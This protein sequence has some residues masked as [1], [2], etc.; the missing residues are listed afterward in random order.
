MMSQRVCSALLLEVPAVTRPRVHGHHQ[1]C[2]L[3]GRYFMCRSA[4]PPPTRRATPRARPVTTN[5]HPR[6]NKRFLTTSKVRSRWTARTTMHHRRPFRQYLRSSQA[7]H[8]GKL[9]S[10]Q[11]LPAPLLGDTRTSHPSTP[12]IPSLS[13]SLSHALFFAS[14]RHP[15]LCSL[16]FYRFIPLPRHH[17]HRCRRRPLSELPHYNYP[18]ATSNQTLPVRCGWPHDLCSH[19]R[20]CRAPTEAVTTQNTSTS[21]LSANNIIGDTNINVDSALSLSLSLRRYLFAA[22]PLSRL[23][24]A[25]RCSAVRKSCCMR[26]CLPPLMVTG[27]TC[28]LCCPSFAFAHGH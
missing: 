1:A 9:T 25:S 26:G 7:K 18:R 24:L 2:R 4:R 22:I 12:M 19:Y 23:P 20:S 16:A 15:T 8:H 3:R 28:L 27:M 11:L 17:R 6:S 10:Y 13:L 5:D 14:V 21:A